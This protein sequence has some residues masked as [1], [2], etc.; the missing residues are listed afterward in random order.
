MVYYLTWEEE[1]SPARRL[2]DTVGDIGNYDSRSCPRPDVANSVMETIS[3]P[4]TAFL[5]KYV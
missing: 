1:G 5:L 3:E 4:E 2:H